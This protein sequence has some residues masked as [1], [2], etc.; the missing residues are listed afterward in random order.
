MAR[1]FR[2]NVGLRAE[3]T[4]VRVFRDPSEFLLDKNGGLSLS[5]LNSNAGPITDPLTGK[6]LP[7]E[8]LGRADIEQVDVLPA[9]SL[10]WDFRPQVKLRFAG[11]RTVARPSFKELAQVYLD[12]PA[13]ADRF[14]GNNR[15]TTS[16]IDNVDLRWEW[17]PSPGDVVAI[18]AF[19]KFIQRPIELFTSPA[20][21]FFANQD[22]AIIYGYEFEVQKG[23]GFLSDELRHFSLGLNATRLYSQVELNEIARD[24]RNSVGLGAK[25]RLQGQPDYLLNFNVAYDNKDRGLYAGL[26]LNVTGETL[27]QAGSLAGSAGFFADVYQ[28]PVSSLDLTVSQKLGQDFKLTFRA[29]NLLNQKTRRVAEGNLDYAKSSGT[30]YSLSLSGAW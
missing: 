8:T 12:D 27:Y 25:R 14:R 19:S 3:Q 24:Q 10:T 17:F 18:S 15:L 29:E 1:N 13:T 5:N 2:V 6:P 20:G 26:F 11:S 28:Q 22:S 4:D 9:L 23:L 7:F 21:D 16:T 30:K